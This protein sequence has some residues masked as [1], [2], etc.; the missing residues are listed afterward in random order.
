VTDFAAADSQPWEKVGTFVEDGELQSVDVLTQGCPAPPKD[1]CAYNYP[2]LRET[3]KVKETREFGLFGEDQYLAISYL[4]S[5]TFDEGEGRNPLTCAADE[6]VLA[7]LPG[8]GLARI[9]WRDA[10]EHTFVFI[11]SVKLYSTPSG[12]S[13]ISVLYCLN[14]TGGC[15]QGMLIWTGEEWR[16]LERDESWTPVYRNLPTGYRPHK[17]P[18]INLGNFTWEQHLAHQNDANCCPS[19]RIYFDLAIVDQKLAVKSYKIVVPEMEAAEEAA[20]RLLATAASELDRL[21]PGDGF[22]LWLNDLLPSGTGRFFELTECVAPGENS[23]AAPGNNL[24]ACLAVDVEIDS[25]DRRFRLLFDRRSL[26][27]RGGEILSPDLDR[28]LDVPFLADLPALLKKAIRVR[29]LK[30]PP[31]TDRKLKEE[32]A[33]LYEW[34]E[35]GQGRRQGPYR[36]WFSTGLYLMEKGEYKNGGK[37]GEWTECNRFEICVSRSYGNDSMP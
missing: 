22:S 3:C 31:E 6:I 23:E 32:Y 20:E 4:R 12:Q 10:T 15:A 5:R 35:D 7:A 33:G 36:S 29:P 13:I 25:R 24:H 37:T 19:G 21:L 34:C 1:L 28:R 14:G 11:S 27:F 16:K 30:C 17:S 2:V 18:K 9:V 26:T 8:G